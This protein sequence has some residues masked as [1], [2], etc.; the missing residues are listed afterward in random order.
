MSR[1]AEFYSQVLGV[2]AEG[3]NIHAAF[4]D[5]QLAIWNPGNID[6]GKF[7]TSERYFTLMYEVD[8]V[9]EEYKRLKQLDIQIEFV[10]EPTTFPWG[11]R[12]FSFKDPDG[13]NIDFLSPVNLQ[14]E[15]KRN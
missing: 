7:Q 1:L 12:S 9:D 8:D 15:N 2:K 6:E 13:N 11:V 3:D 14:P 5:F 10:Q 4:P